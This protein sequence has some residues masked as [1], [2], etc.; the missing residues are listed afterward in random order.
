[1]SDQLSKILLY[2][3]SHPQCNTEEPLFGY[4]LGQLVSEQWIAE[5]GF[6]RTVTFMKNIPDYQFEDQFE[7]EFGISMNDWLQ[8]R[9]LPYLFKVL[10]EE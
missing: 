7:I 3:H 1:M 6:E 10:S 5:F 8:T 4:R 9:A 2:G